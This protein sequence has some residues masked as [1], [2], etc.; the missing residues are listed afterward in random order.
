MTNNL[1]VKLHKCPRCSS[2]IEKDGGC[3]HMSCPMC[4]HSWCWTCGFPRKHFFHTITREM[5]CSLYNNIAFNENINCRNI[6]IIIFIG[7][8]TI[9]F[10]PTLGPPVLYFACIG[11][12]AYLLSSCLFKRSYNCCKTCIFLL[13]ILILTI[14]LATIFFAC[15]IVVIALAIIF[16]PL[17]S[18]FLLMRIIYQ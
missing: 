16:I 13:I 2:S 10:G 7:T 4:D 9:V 3:P 1:G 5:I 11:C 6:L 18:L 12:S 8:L 15:C 14:P 17:L